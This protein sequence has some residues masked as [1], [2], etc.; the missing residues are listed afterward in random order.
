MLMETDEREAE[1]GQADAAGSDGVGS[2]ALPTRH[3]LAAAARAA[4]V[5][6]H[7][8]TRLTDARDSY[9]ALPS[10]GIYRTPDLLRGERLLLSLG[11]LRE[12][13]GVLYPGREA[14]VL[15]CLSEAEGIEMLLAL[16]LKRAPPLWLT[17]VT[18]G[19]DVALE[20]L[21]GEATG[22]LEQIVG[23]EDAQ[24]AFLRGVAS[25]VDP[26]RN[27]ETG[28]LAEEH[29]AD[30]CREELRALGREQLAEQVQR[31][32]LINDA[33]GYDVAAPRVD[34]SVRHLEVK[35]SRSQGGEARVFLSRNEVARALTDPD[36][37]LTVCQISAEDEVQLWGW[38]TAGSFADQLPVDRPGN[39]RWESASLKLVRRDLARGLPPATR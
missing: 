24:A 33:A 4:S 23:G 12:E 26:E 22:L 32:S 10:G 14:R 30:L 8:G 35:G 16:L 36:W 34:A 3:Q 1:A 9:M 21:P 20:Y 17:G 13:D 6:S 37:A 31:I 27:A 2:R 19:D 18:D 5:L 39:A 15:A 38:T 7:A 11:I 28:R 25:K 29:V